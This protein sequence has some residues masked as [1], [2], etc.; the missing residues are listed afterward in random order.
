MIHSYLATHAYLVRM[1]AETRQQV[2]GLPYVRAVVPCHP[3]YKSAEFDAADGAPEEPTAYNILVFQGGA[4]VLQVIADRVVAVGG[5]VDALPVSGLLLRA[6]LTGQQ[7]LEVVRLP[8]VASVGRYSPPVAFVDIARQIGGG[9]YVHDTLGYTGEGVTGEVMDTGHPGLHMEYPGS[10][11]YPEGFRRHGGLFFPWC[12]HPTWAIGVTFAIGAGGPE[13][14]LEYEGQ[15][16]GFLPGAGPQNRIV[17]DV[18]W[19]NSGYSE[20]RK[21]HTEQLLDPSVYGAVFQTNSWGTA[22]DGSYNE[23]TAE[24]DDMLCDPS[25]ELFLLHGAARGGQPFSQEAVAKNVLAV[26]GI[27]HY[28][29]LSKGDDTF[30]EDHPDGPTLDGRIKPDLVHFAD[31]VLTSSPA[32]WPEEDAATRFLINTG[33]TFPARVRPRR[34]QPDTPVCSS[35]CGRRMSSR[36]MEAEPT[37]S[38]PGRI[39]A[40]RR[41]C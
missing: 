18:Q 13:E 24:L 35:R 36:R 23:V 3:A 8:E 14:G 12:S 33:R 1:T 11:E 25:S 39:S 31:A 26:G 16:K 19:V 40:R 6:T 21:V 4:E 7:L 38:A 17:A 2:Q 9:T 10:A 28:D 29:T 30:P 32:G 22:P 27:L 34:S 15:A 37:S 20:G 41:R 5:V